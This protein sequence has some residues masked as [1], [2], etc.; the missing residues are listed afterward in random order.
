MLLE[1]RLKG[2][3]QRQAESRVIP[4]RPDPGSAPLSFAQCQMWVIDQMT[5]GNP[6]Y[7]LPV[8]YRIHGRL[9]ATALENGFNEIIQRHEALRTTFTASDGEPLQLI[10][11][12]HKIKIKI[13]KLAHLA[14]E[15]RENTL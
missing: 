3:A 15:E 10:H 5:P 2:A 11:S 9:D 1:Q 13:T 7:D 6:A 8:G 12:E 14:G 4:K